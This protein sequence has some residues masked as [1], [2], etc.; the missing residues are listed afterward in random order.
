MTPTDNVVTFFTG[1]RQS[2]VT[3][4]LIERL[5]NVA[6]TASK[7]ILLTTPATDMKKEL[8]NRLP[9]ELIK[10]EQIEIV[11]IKDV[12][13]LLKYLET[14]K[15]SAVFAD[16]GLTAHSALDWTLI[17]AAYNDIAF[18]VGVSHDVMPIYSAMRRS[19]KAQL[20]GRLKS[21]KVTEKSP[22]GANV[23]TL[24]L[25]DSP[26]QPIQFDEE[27]KALVKNLAL[28]SGFKLKDQGNGVM[29]L[30]PYVYDFACKLSSYI[31]EEFGYD[32]FKRQLE[33]DPAYL[34]SWQCNLAMTI[35]DA[36]NGNIK[37]RHANV[38]AAQFL[39]RA[40]DLDVTALS[41]WKDFEKQWMS[42]GIPTAYLLSRDRKLNLLLD[43]GMIREGV[44][45]IPEFY[46]LVVKMMECSMN[47]FELTPDALGRMVAQWFVL[48]QSKPYYR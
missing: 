38:A 13:A 43:N 21:L 7:K 27:F 47:E 26:Y 34:W 16:D 6:P 39:N 29:D 36:V 17:A 40:F 4:S 46:E 37:H 5:V 42:D 19:P 35:N 41:E 44:V 2:G 18:C 30:N 11:K 23:T 1:I 22:R 10:T 24:T 48:H 33:T 45:V 20:L 28:T 12:E 3:T 32:K 8:F 25:D 14:E 31:P 9:N 15:Y